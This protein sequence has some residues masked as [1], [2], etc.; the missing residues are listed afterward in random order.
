MSEVGISKKP[1]VAKV[2]DIAT[3]PQS[4]FV[5]RSRREA[6]FSATSARP[7]NLDADIRPV[8]DFI[9]G[10]AGG[11]AAAVRALVQAY[12]TVLTYDVSG[13]LEP[14]VAFLREL[15]VTAP[16]EALVE[17]P[18]LLGLETGKMRQIVDYLRSVDTPADQVMDYITKSI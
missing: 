13:R 14:L 7:L 5:D 10:E 9:R 2:I 15:G 11:D 12:P 16:V 4:G 1:E 17:R 6:K 3:N 8:V 18:S